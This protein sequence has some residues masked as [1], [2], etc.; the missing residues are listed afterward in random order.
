MNTQPK[1]VMFYFDSLQRL[2][3]FDSF[4]IEP[5]KVSFYGRRDDI[6]WYS[7]IGKIRSDIEFPYP[8]FLVADVA[9][10]DYAKLFAE[11][12]EQYVNNQANNLIA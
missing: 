3:D 10:E 12:C 7:I 8:E 9:S 1:S 2:R 4:R 6:T 5:A 11:L